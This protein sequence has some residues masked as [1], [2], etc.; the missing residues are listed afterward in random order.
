MT[1]A[2]DEVEL[3]SWARPHF[4]PSGGDAHL[5]FKVHG[6]FRDG[7]EVSG[8][9]HRTAGLPSGCDVRSIRRDTQRSAFELGLEAGWVG[10]AFRSDAPDVAAEVAKAEDCL[11]LAGTVPDPP[12]LDYFRD[13]VGVVTAML[14][15]GGVAV[16]DAHILKWWSRSEWMEV[17]S[18]RVPAP[19]AH[20]VILVSDDEGS[21]RGSPPTRWFHTRGMRK[22]GRP[23]LSVRGVTGELELAVVDLLNRFIE[24]QAFGGV[25][26]DGQEI[27][28]KA[29]PRGWRCIHGGDVDD[30]DFNNVHVEIGPPRP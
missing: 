10:D 21:M 9:R 29:L 22:F 5:F 12:T 2:S 19:R 11:I 16:F 13:A 3:E 23:D 8:G 25:I 4:V 14:D 15:A 1:N 30:P 17:V 18:R 24:L 20:V 6:A 28:M 26:A 7:L 27:W